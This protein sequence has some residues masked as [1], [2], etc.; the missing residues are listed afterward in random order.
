MGNRFFAT[1]RKR[2]ILTAV[3]GGLFL[4]GAL[5]GCDMS[6]HQSTIVTEGP[7]ARSQ[8]HLFYVTLGVSVFIFLTVGGV[9]AYAQI[10]FRAKKGQAG[11]DDP[12]P[13]THGHPLVEIGLIA[14]S[15]LLLVIIAV[16]TVR[17]IWYTQETPD[18][19]NALEVKVTGYQWWFKFD[20][21][22]LG[23]STANELVIPSDRPIHLE[24]RTLDVI[25][26]FWVPKLAGKTDMIPNRANSMWLQADNEGYYWGQCAE[27]CGESHANMKFRLVSLEADEFEAWAE[28]QLAEAR[29][30]TDGSVAETSADLNPKIVLA[31][32]TGDAP[33]ETELSSL[34]G[35][36]EAQRP[37][38]DENVALVAR[39]RELFREKTCLMCHEIRGHGSPGI[40][41]PSLTHFGSRTTVAAGLL[42]NTEENLAHWLREPD[43]VK[44]GNL[45]YRDGYVINNI[46]LTEDDIQALVAYLHSLK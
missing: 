16:P 46:E 27:F 19:E 13:Q 2:S 24:L 33:T 35:W 39:G 20:Y 1:F 14:I 18:R 5:S 17:G 34:Q 21:P 11:A 3:L 22:E 15:G 32:L 10:R 8:L 26:S 9:L 30:V 6:G 41:G 43:Y 4:L 12:P 40:T 37:A 42:E 45:M 25:H 31:G 38:E 36:R 44:P 29:N 28:R 23:I 7:V